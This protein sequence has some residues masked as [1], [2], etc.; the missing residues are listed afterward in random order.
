MLD[1]LFVQKLTKVSKTE[2]NVDLSKKTT[3]KIGGV[4]PFFV[5]PASRTEL[6]AVLDLCRQYK[7]NYRILGAGSNVLVRDNVDFIVISTLKLK[8]TAIKSNGLVYA[9]AGA[10]LGEIIRLAANRGLSGIEN[11]VGIPA[12]IGGA[13]VMNAG[14]FGT[15]IGDCVLFVDVY[16]KGRIKRISLKNLFFEYRHSVFTKSKKY[17]IIGVALLLKKDSKVDVVERI[18]TTVF[19]RSKSQKI[20]Y[21]N[22]GSIFK[23]TSPLAPAYMIQQC[24]LKGFLIGSAQVSN[25]HSGFIINLGNSTCQDV[26]KVIHYVRRKVKQTFGVWLQLEI[27]LL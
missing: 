21:P 10:K 6:V 14:A 11:L 18:R 25:I 20:G 23:K 19:A 7:V 22:A 26:I 13:V 2:K 4:T 1:P 9:E 12:S 15:Q 3:F 27:I 16:Y 5:S 8:K 24:G 17:V